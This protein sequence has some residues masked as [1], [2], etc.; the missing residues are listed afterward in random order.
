MGEKGSFLYRKDNVLRLAAPNVTVRDCTGAG[1]GSVAGFLL[2]KING[3]DD[4]TCLKVAHTLSAE[5]LQVSG[6]IAHHLN[7]T[8]LLSLIEKYY[9][10]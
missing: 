7:R 2:G 10:E 8:Q 1:D 9:P 4:E 3:L 6:A 5:I